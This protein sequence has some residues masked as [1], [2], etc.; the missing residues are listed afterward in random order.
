LD[1]SEARAHRQRE[2]KAR[3]LPYLALHPDAAPVQLDEL[4]RQGQAKARPSH[5]LVRCPHLTKLL[6]DRLLI[7]WRDA[8]AGIGHGY[9]Y[10]PLLHFREHVYAAALGGELERVGEQV[11]EHLLDLALIP[12]DR[13]HAI[14]D[15]PSKRDVAARCPLAHESQRVVDGARQV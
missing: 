12:L 8:N 1:Y 6:E 13:A 5:L 7:L 15:R 11:Q 10:Q 9:L 3:A 14:L 4:P 2:R